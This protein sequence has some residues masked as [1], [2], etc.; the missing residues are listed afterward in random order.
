MVELVTDR[1]VIA[2]PG[3]SHIDDVFRIMSTR[4]L[5]E[6]TG[7]KKMDDVSEAEGKIRW[8]MRTDN[9]LVIS[10]KDGD[11]VIGI[12][13][14]TP[15][16]INL[17]QGTLMDYEI[18]YFIETS[19]QGN[20]YMTEALSCIKEYLF[21]VRKADRLTIYLE[22]DNGPSRKV[23]LAG[24]FKFSH[25][26][27]EAGCRYDGTMTDLEFYILDRQDSP[28]DAGPC[29][30]N[31]L[32]R[33]KWI[34]EGG[35]LFPIP[36]SAT[37][38][39]TPGNGVFRIYVD[40]RTGRIGLD[41]IAESF[42]VNF[43]VYGTEGKA[44]NDHI[45][46]TWNSDVFQKSGKNLGVIFNGLKGTGKTIAAKQLCNRLGLPTIVVSKPVDGLLEFIQALN[47]EAAVLID[48][49]EKTFDEESEILLKMIDGVYNHRRKLYILTTN[50]LTLD[51]N[52]IGR[53]G[54]IRYVKQ[55][56]NLELDVINE[57]IADTLEDKSLADGLIRLVNSLEIST[58]DILKSIIEE[59]N[60]TGRIPDPNLFNVPLSNLKLR[61][62][63]FSDLDEVRFEDVEKFIVENKP[64]SM[65]I[66][67]W[68]DIKKDDG[69]DDSTWQSFIEKEFKCDIRKE[70][71]SS[72]DNVVMKGGKL[73]YHKVTTEPDKYGFFSWE[74]YGDEELLCYIGFTDRPSL[75]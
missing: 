52:L 19:F 48:E 15:E 10:K 61:L 51:D 44:I 58:I 40:A 41:K 38:L 55:F 27:K 46:H 69:K 16:E 21:N 22:P 18:C 49:A 67:Q 5:A 32:N 71:V 60:I 66:E 53:P 54:R 33:Q 62:L 74:Y 72:R 31:Y 36:G 7:F 4:C 68:M 70:S 11:D 6:R 56:G 3:E 73:G 45:I 12:I 42:I 57:V 24:G 47:F 65:P 39:S 17:P 9:M 20:G 50:E 35:V 28:K 1:L 26:E 59:C 43:K 13:I 34:N 37:L 23:A 75:Y 30:D 64:E 2:T 14:L 63:R 25:V 29:T 8:A